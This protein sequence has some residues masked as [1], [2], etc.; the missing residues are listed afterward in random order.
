MKPIKI[1]GTKG[2]YVI[3]NGDEVPIASMP[4]YVIKHKM[5]K[6]PI[7]KKKSRKKKDK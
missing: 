6:Q 7:P 3:D 1:D 2:V 4:E 5:C